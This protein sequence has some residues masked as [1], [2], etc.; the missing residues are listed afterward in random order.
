LSSEC[1]ASDAAERADVFVVPEGIG[2]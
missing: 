1:E 2:R